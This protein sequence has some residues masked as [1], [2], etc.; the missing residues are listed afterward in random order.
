MIF[1]IFEAF[2]FNRFFSVTCDFSG[3]NG[4]F[5]ND[6]QKNCDHRDNVSCDLVSLNQRFG[7][8]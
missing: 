3:P 1:E 7:A 2:S 8:D 4:T 5:W 6:T